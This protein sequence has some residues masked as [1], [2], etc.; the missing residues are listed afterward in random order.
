[1]TL[2]FV[3]MLRVTKYHLKTATDSLW[4]LLPEEIRDLPLQGLLF[5]AIL[6]IVYHAPDILT[7]IHESERR[8][9]NGDDNLLLH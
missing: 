1:M 4:N 2:L 6:Y 5:L 9:E 8:R 7:A 3:R